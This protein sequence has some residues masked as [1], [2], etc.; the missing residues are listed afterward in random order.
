MT[1]LKWVLAS[2]LLAGTSVLL[3]CSHA[4]AT[5]H[6]T[7]ITAIPAR[8]KRDSFNGRRTYVTGN[9][10]LNKLLRVSAF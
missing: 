5:A 2:Q 10:L 3:A 9:S 1:K 4:W 7:A 8:T 6:N